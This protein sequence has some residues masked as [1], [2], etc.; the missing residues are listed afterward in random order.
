MHLQT[1]WLALRSQFLGRFFVCCRRKARNS[2]AY[3]YKRSY[4]AYLPLACSVNYASALAFHNGVAFDFCLPVMKDR[5]YYPD[6]RTLPDFE[7][8]ANK[9]RACERN[10]CATHAQLRR[11]SRVRQTTRGS[12][13]FVAVAVMLHSEHSLFSDE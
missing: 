9:F 4:G 12:V 10:A 2:P 1:L 5:T 8:N 11:N 3:L 13:D 7:Q 6:H